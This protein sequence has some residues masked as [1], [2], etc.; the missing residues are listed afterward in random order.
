MNYAK[1]LQLVYEIAC[2]EQPIPEAP[3]LEKRRKAAAVEVSCKY[4]AASQAAGRRVGAC[5]ACANVSCP[6]KALAAA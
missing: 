5:R 4:G 2:L 3:K 6:V 1:W